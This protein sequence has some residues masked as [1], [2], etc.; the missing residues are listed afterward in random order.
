MFKKSTL[1]LLVA[2]IY[3][4]TIFAQQ[5]PRIYKEPEF[6]I[7][8]RKPTNH[9][10]RIILSLGADPSTSASVTWRTSTEIDSA[11]AEIAIANAAPK[12]WRNAKTIKAVTTEFNAKDIDEADVISN[13]H[14]VKFDGLQSDTIYAYRVGDGKRWSEWIQFR[15]ASN[16]PNKTFSFLYVG[17]AQNYIL[18]L[19]SRLIREGYRKAPNAKFIVHAGDLVN[20]AHN[21]QQWQEWFDAGSFIHSSIGAFPVPG[22]HEYRSLIK[23]GEKVLSAQWS[24]QFTLPENG[25]DD[26][27]ESAYYMDY[28][29]MRIIALNSNV[30]KEEQAK[31]IEKILSKTDKEWIIVTF[32][33]PLYSASKGRDNKEWRDLLK[34]IFDKYNVDLVLQGHDHS[35]ARGRVSPND[36][37]LSN[38][39]VMD[40]INMRD[41]TGTVYVVSVSG[42]KMYHLRPNAWE[43][44]D[45]ERERAAENTQL[46]QVI[47]IE[48]NKLSFESYTAI[49]ELYDAFDLIKEKNN[50][51]QF[52]ERKNQAI[53]ERR[54][55]NTIPYHDPLPEGVEKIILN[56]YKGFEIDGVRFFKDDKNIGYNVKLEKGNEVI[57]LILDKEG[58]ILSEKKQ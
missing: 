48:R 30:K 39:N 3:S 42:G 52:I 13:Y 24:Y 9:P 16:S 35:Y 37:T 31:W 23:D 15:T 6:D 38:D 28:Q 47:T 55:S 54:F 56:K 25:P 2:F 14:S 45:A 33:H 19:W 50:P 26:L 43:G 51:N 27:K 57:N 11:Y 34:P 1:L 49:G 21:E 5:E 22:N 7:E 12:F 41:K 17:D 40:G 18:E 53:E 10:D 44:W 36:N 4:A 8:W 58:K 20:S 32:H 46:F 29:N